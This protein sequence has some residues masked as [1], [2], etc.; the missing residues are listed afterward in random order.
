M[1]AQRVSSGIPLNT[2]RAPDD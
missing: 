2:V 1:K